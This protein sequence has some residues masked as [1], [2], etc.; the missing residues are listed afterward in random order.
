MSILVFHALK[1]T[2]IFCLHINRPLLFFYSDIY[3][4]FLRYSV[5]PSICIHK[6]TFSSVFFYYC[7][8][9]CLL[10]FRPFYEIKVIWIKI[11]IL[12]FILMLSSFAYQL[13]FFYWNHFCEIC[14]TCPIV[15][16]F[17]VYSSLILNKFCNP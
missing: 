3:N 13:H 10:L 4:V 15:N 17:Q 1:L 7:I 6:F 2:S 5:S 12:F 16:P 14:F 9:C 8:N 11:N